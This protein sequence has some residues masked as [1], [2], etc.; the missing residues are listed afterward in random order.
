M[1]KIWGLTDYLYTG[2]RYTINSRTFEIREKISEGGYAYVHKAIDLSTN[3]EF[4]VK[5]ILCQT[6]ELIQMAEREISIMRSLPVHENIVRYYDSLITTQGS[7]TLVIIIME[8]C[9]G[10]TLVNL[11]EKYNGQLSFAQLYYIAKEI[12]Q[13]VLAV[14]AAGFIHR[15]LKIENILLNNKKFKLCDFGS[16]SNEVY[17]LT[18]ANRL[19]LLSLQE[20]FERETTLMYRP[21]EMIDLYQRGRIDFKVDS[22]MIGCIIYTLAFC[23]HP[24]QD[25]AQL[26]IVNGHYN[27]PQNSRFDNKFHG[28][29]SWIL[30]PNPSER[31]SV[32]EI[33][34]GLCDYE[35]TACFA[36]VPVKSQKRSNKRIDRDLTQEEIEREMQLI[37]DQMEGKANKLLAPNTSNSE[38][39]KKKEDF[40]IWQSPLEAPA[41]KSQ[42]PQNIGWAKF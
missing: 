8:L 21:P 29:I 24:F 1:N 35:V 16:C 27:F 30:N 41:P 23:K 42:N 11:L 7:T 31:P 12:C 15:D 3:Q 38:N 5:K 20:K 33:Y 4:A 39:A 37:R 18:N 25:Q 2:E 10:G 32:Q 28:F 13:G 22:W 9:T 40:N 17:E 19:E 36:A 26:A 34:N 14:H 6:P